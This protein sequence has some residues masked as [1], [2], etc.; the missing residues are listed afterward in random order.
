MLLYFTVV[1]IYYCLY[2]VGLRVTRWRREPRKATEF[3]SIMQ[4]CG[5]LRRSRSFKVTDFGT[6]R[7]P[8][9]ELILSVLLILT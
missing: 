7:K 2:I 6:N 8:I 9:C 4:T 3:G 1:K 5:L